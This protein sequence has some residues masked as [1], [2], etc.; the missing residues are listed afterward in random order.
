MMQK[1]TPAKK[2]RFVTTNCRPSTQLFAGNWQSDQCS[3]HKA[4]EDLNVFKVIFGNWIIN[5]TTDAGTGGTMMIEAS[6][7]Y[8]AGVLKRITFNGGNNSEI[9]ANGANTNADFI[10]VDIPK[11]AIFGVRAFATF[12]AAL[13]GG[14]VNT[15]A[16]YNAFTAGATNNNTGT[17][18]SNIMN[19]I[20]SPTYNVAGVP[21]GVLGI[22]AYTDN[23]AFLLCG[24][25]ITQGN[26]TDTADTTFLYGQAERSVEWGFSN[27]G[28]GGEGIAGAIT[29]SLKRG[30]LFKYASDV[31][32]NYGTNDWAGGAAGSTIIANLNTYLSNYCNNHNIH[33]AT[34]IP[35]YV[36]GIFSTEVGQVLNANN[37]KRRDF[38]NLLL[39]GGILR[40]HRI[41]DLNAITANSYDGSL[42]KAFPTPI[43]TDGTHPNQIGCNY[44]AS[45]VNLKAGH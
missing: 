27:V 9:V 40:K 2:L 22:V 6:I 32:V 7:E 5:S 18:V 29:A 30:G 43:T 31:Y 10:S 45:K 41:V 17:G 39:S 23:P 42:W 33:V 34:L 28:L 36:T 13:A 16:T 19:P 14:T 21:V 35:S 26:G 12:S 3:L 8:P 11:N 44:I 15:I 24:D 4:T 25:S 20:P 37:Q 1:L 38:N